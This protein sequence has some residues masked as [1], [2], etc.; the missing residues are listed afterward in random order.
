MKKTF[1]SNIDS[2]DKSQRL[3]KKL[4]TF[5]NKQWVENVILCITII[6]TIVICLINNNI[7][8]DLKAFIYQISLGCTIIFIAEMVIKIYVL[9]LKGYVTSSFYNVTDGIFTLISIGELL[10]QNDNGAAVF[11]V[12]RAFRVLR[13]TKFLPQLSNLIA[14]FCDSAKPL[15]SLFTIWGLSIISFSLFAVQFFEGGMNFSNNKPRN[16][17]ENFF[18]SFLS[19]IQLYTVENWDSIKTNVSE[20]K[21]IYAT[22]IPVIIIII[23]AYIF[24]QFLI[25]ILLNSILDRLKND[26]Y[27]QELNNDKRDAKHIIKYVFNELFDAKFDANDEVFSS[28]NNLDGPQYAALATE[29]EVDEDEENNGNKNHNDNIDKDKKKD[30][31]N[32]KNNK[33]EKEKNKINMDDKHK[34]DKHTSLLLNET[35]QKHNTI[36]ETLKRNPTN[37]YSEYIQKKQTLLDTIRRNPTTIQVESSI[38]KQPTLLQSLRRDPSAHLIEPVKKSKTL[39]QSLKRN[40]TT[41]NGEPVSKRTSIFNDIIRNRTTISGGNNLS[42]KNKNKQEELT[43]S[44]L[45]ES[46]SSTIPL[47]ILNKGKSEYNSSSTSPSSQTTDLDEYINNNYSSDEK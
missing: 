2:N 24:S 43:I 10:I 6:D 19:V 37:R 23:G 25:A 16:N 31:F 14:V 44:P 11:R 40:R 29:S 41:V 13:L 45:N 18:Y 21:N 9:G 42:P 35:L 33:K 38:Q 15:L 30:K 46:F 8:E 1:I 20:S 34:S 27:F 4:E 39:L 12:L 5:I 26:F 47:R 17:F 7:S 28:N 32:G 3:R 36:L 22:I